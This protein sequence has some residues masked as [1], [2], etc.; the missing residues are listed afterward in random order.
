MIILSDEKSKF[1]KSLF[2]IFNMHCLR[3][4]NIYLLIIKNRLLNI[5][6]TLLKKTSKPRKVQKAVAKPTTTTE[7]IPEFNRD[8]VALDVPPELIG[9]GYSL[10]TK[11]GTILGSLVMVKLILNN[12]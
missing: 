6:F 3:K 9:N 8:K 5:F 12:K 1:Q 2:K 7:K 4:Q 10:L 11:I